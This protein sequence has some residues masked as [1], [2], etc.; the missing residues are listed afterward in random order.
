M[1]WIKA[2]PFVRQIWNWW[3]YYSGVNREH[4][5]SIFKKLDAIANEERIDEIIN[6]SLPGS[7]HLDVT[8]L[9]NDFVTGLRRFE[10]QY[11]DP[12]IQP[13][14]SELAWEL[15]RLTA[16]VAR[17]FFS[18]G[19]HRIKFYPDP[20]DRSHYDTQFKVLEKCLLATWEAYRTYRL[21]IKD[22]LMI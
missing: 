19:E 1:D 20:I 2:F 8:Y 10:N 3:R 9:L 22:R 17:T 15:N 4:D 6:H 13:R 12:T 18:I 14:A 7:I 21:S 11:L 5:I 16:H